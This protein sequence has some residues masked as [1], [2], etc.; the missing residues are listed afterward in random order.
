M[1]I[2]YKDIKYRLQPPLD[3]SS[4]DDL[5]GKYFFS[6]LLINYENTDLSG[7]VLFRCYPS[8]VRNAVEVEPALSESDV[9]T[10][11]GLDLRGANF[12]GDVLSGISFEGSNLEGATLA[13]ARLVYANFEN[14]N[15]KDVYFNGADLTEAC[16]VG[17][18]LDGAS[19]NQVKLTGASLENASLRESD[20]S[21][22]MLHKTSLRGAVTLRVRN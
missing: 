11:N 13:N 21:V 14:A 18:N 19:M 7:C 20:L 9:T 3:C 5:R 6:R 16:L 1:S 15:L 10:L 8:G 17:A 4:V 22:A 12:A 2:T